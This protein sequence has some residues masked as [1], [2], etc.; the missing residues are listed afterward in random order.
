MPGRR[1]LLPIAIEPT[2]HFTASIGAP[3]RSG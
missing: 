1:G 3:R 2:I